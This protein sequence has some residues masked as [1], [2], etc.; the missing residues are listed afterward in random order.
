MAGKPNTD[1]QKDAQKGGCIDS[2]AGFIFR[3]MEL[4]FARVGTLVGTRPWLF[5]LVSFI[6]FLICASG[7]SQLV[8]ESRGEK[9]WVPGGTEAQ[10]DKDIV[11]DANFPRFARFEEIVISSHP[12]GENVLKPEVLDL[13][14]EIDGRIEKE[15]A[16]NPFAEKEGEKLLL[17]YNATGPDIKTM[18][19]VR[20]GVCVKNSLLDLFDNDPE[21]W[22]T[23]ELILEKIN[24]EN[25]TSSSGD[26]VEILSIL[27]GVEMDGDRIVGAQGISLAY[28]IENNGVTTQEEGEEDPRGEAWE[29]AFLDLAEEEDGKARVKGYSIDRFAGRSFQDEF[30]DSI[31]GDLAKLNIAIVLLLAYSIT[32]LSKWGEGCVGSRVTL[33][34]GGFISIGMAIAAALGIGSYLGLFYSPLMGV[35]PFLLI[36]IGVDDVFVLVSAL[37]RI[38]EHLPMPQR[39]SAALSVSGASITVTSLTDFFAFVIGSNTSLPALRNFSLYAA[40]GILLTLIFQVTFFAGWLTYDEKLRR[41]NS[42]GDCLCCVKFS[43]TSCC[44]ADDKILPRIMEALGKLLS[45]MHVKIG[46]LVGFAAI[47]AVGIVGVTQIE[48]DADVDDFIPSGSYLGSWNNIKEDLFTSVGDG[49]GV[50]M[51][52]VDF[53]SPE[54]QNQMEDLFEDFR[55][56]IYTVPSTCQSWYSEFR[57]SKGGDVIPREDFYPEL[58]SWLNTPPNL[59]GGSNFKGDIV[60]E[61]G[62]IVISRFTGSQTRTQKSRVL[63]RQMN[64]LRAMVDAFPA[65]LGPNSFAYGSNYVQVEQYKA[66]GREAITNIGLALLMVLVIV[67]ILLVN[68]LASII[69]FLC[70]ALVVIELV[71]FMHFWG[72]SVDNVVVIFLVISLGLSVDYAVHIAHAFLAMSGTPNERMVKALAEIGPAVFHGAMSTFIA[73]L[74]LSLSQSYVFESFFRSLFLCVLL[75]LGHGIILLPVALSILAPSTQS[76]G[77]HELPSQ[78][79]EENPSKTFGDSKPETEMVSA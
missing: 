44:R 59:G 31:E 29:Q 32:M 37:D 35:F 54:I 75:G 70:V 68:P 14:F 76:S 2:V 47:A 78:P 13:L 73:V 74:V 21:A 41:S 23:E 79:E 42:R 3:G 60:M 8:N 10:K 52:N 71:G 39:L 66:I 30:G 49:T 62:K 57:I 15:T 22:K 16:E 53:A 72:A 46:V 45:L 61:N 48:V 34:V 36:G 5:M 38:P 64:S 33:A 51:Q 50:Y 17:A 20:A 65:P 63:V 11:E 19:F 24:S 58:N 18:C 12:T 69:T 9:L 7:L 28:F 40:M 56:N 1:K 6:A 4:F 25:L 27:G 77:L 55:D 67:V 43:K 26:S